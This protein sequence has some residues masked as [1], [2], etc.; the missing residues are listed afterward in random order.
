MSSAPS[1]LISEPSSRALRVPPHSIPAEQAVLGGVLLHPASW[2][3]IVELLSEEDFY[4][5]GHRLLFRAIAALRAETRAA[6]FLTLAEWLRAHG[7]LEKIGGDAYLAEL[8][9]GTPSAANARDYALILRDCSVRRQLIESGTQIAATAYATGALSM[10]QLVDQAERSIFEIASNRMRGR[11]SYRTLANVLAGALDRIDEL[12]DKNSHITGIATG[13]HDFDELTSGLQPSDLIV[14]AGR[15]SMGKTAFAMNIAEHAAIREERKVA[16]FSME[17]SGQQLATRMLASLAH[18]NQQKLRTGQ[19]HPDDW[20][21]LDCAIKLMERAPI[22]VDDTPALSPTALSGCCRRM[23][24]ERGLD[25]VVIDYLQLMHIPG[26][27][28]NRATE[29]SGISN[30]LKALAKELD[31]PV[32]ALSQLNRSVEQRTDHKPLMS[33]LRES[34]AIEQDADLIAF[35]YRDEVYHEDSPDRGTAEIIVGKQRNGPIGTVKL[36]FQARFTCFENLAKE[37]RFPAPAG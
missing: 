4:H 8:S 33:D 5:P 9:E 28:E 21:N 6:D 15:P 27:V 2:D 31:I 29:L 34:G 37:D 26:S 11:D 36:A 10:E 30:A 16:I 14:I 35:V 20:K 17:M 3:Q 18:V 12:K 13:F 23:A 1:E 24:R 32:V 19:L 25:L 22:F 7:E